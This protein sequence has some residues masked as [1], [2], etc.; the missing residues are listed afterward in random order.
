MAKEHGKHDGHDKEITLQF[1]VEQQHDIMRQ[2]IPREEWVRFCDQF[3][4]QHQGWLVSIGRVA[5]EKLQGETR[6]V[7]G[8]GEII[9]SDVTLEEIRAAHGDTGL[10]IRVLGSLRPDRYEYSVAN[11][12][13]LH[14]LRSAEDEHLGLRVDDESGATTLIHFRSA[15]N[16]ELLDGVAPAERYPADKGL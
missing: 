10:E 5:T 1:L 7:E 14:F 16:P 8:Q 13:A 2:E 15:S 11:P 6:T 12:V 3:T 9:E 4:R